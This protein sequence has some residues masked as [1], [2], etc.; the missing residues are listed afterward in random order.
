MFF[1]IDISILSL[2]QSVLHQVPVEILLKWRL[3]S[4]QKETFQIRQAIGKNIRE[5]RQQLGLTQEQFAEI[6][7]LSVQ[8]LSAL[9]NGA[10]FARMG[11]YYKIAEALTLPLGSLFA[12]QLFQDCALDEQLRLLLYDFE[13]D[14][15]KA[16][17]DI[18]RTI[19]AL[20]LTKHVF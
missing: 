20:L 6:V 1:Y 17:L 10:Q 12:M 18:I 16:L 11:T 14:E 5:G 2:F 8:S 19:K 15:K 3:I 13:T 9:E 4:M 7:E